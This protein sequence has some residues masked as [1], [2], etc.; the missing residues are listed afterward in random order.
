MAKSPDADC[1]ISTGCKTNAER[2]G[3]QPP[4]SLGKVM[5]QGF[6]EVLAACGCPPSL[7]VDADGT[8]QREAFRRFFSVT[9]EPLGRLLEVELSAKLETDI[10]LSFAGRFSAD[11]SGRARAFQSMVG[12]GMDVSKAA[13][14]SGLMTVEG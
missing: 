2:L 5:S 1:P 11:L 13:A 12:G 4:E 3:P 8:A 9:V 6:T 14:L 10:R 7:F